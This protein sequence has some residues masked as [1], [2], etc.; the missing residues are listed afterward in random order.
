MTVQARAVVPWLA[1]SAGVACR[2]RSAS[3]IHSRDM[4]ANSLAVAK[5]IRDR[6]HDAEHRQC[7]AVDGAILQVVRKPRS[8]MSC[9]SHGGA[10]CASTSVI[11]ADDHP[12]RRRNLLTWLRRG[13]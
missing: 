4:D 6:A 1:I 10:G 7:G 9:K 13:C 5:P 12:D 3:H 2:R 11:G 8:F